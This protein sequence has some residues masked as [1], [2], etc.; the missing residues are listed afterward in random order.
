[1]VSFRF[2]QIVRKSHG[3]G[4]KRAE[5][6]TLEVNNDGRRIHRYLTRIRLKMV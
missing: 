6:G 4:R 1:M 5:A 3:L 2:P